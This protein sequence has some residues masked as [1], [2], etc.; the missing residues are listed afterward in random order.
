MEK[1]NS[2]LL[3]GV[4]RW[5]QNL[6]YRVEYALWSLNGPATLA[7]VIETVRSQ[8]GAFGKSKHVEH[9]LVG[10]YLRGLCQGKRADKIAHGVYV[11]PDFNHDIFS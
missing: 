7:E 4:T 3:R 10:S 6:K 5:D 11:H 1:P 2:F 8:N 9:C